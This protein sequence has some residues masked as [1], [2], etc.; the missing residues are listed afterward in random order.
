MEWIEESEYLPL[1]DVRGLNGKRWTHSKYLINI[2]YLHDQGPGAIRLSPPRI[3]Q[4]CSKQ[5]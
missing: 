2:T 4:A 1:R 5:M 3:V